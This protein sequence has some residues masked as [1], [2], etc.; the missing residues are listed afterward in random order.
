MFAEDVPFKSPS[1][2]AVVV[3][4]GN[5][6]GRTAWKIAETGQTYGEWLEQKVAAAGGPTDVDV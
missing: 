2:A 3:N 5:M 4:A 1:A 6:N